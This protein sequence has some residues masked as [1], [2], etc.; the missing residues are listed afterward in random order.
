[1]ECQTADGHVC[2]VQGA[3]GRRHR[4]WHHLAGRLLSWLEMIFDLTLGGPVDFH[5]VLGRVGGKAWGGEWGEKP[6]QAE[7]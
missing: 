3:D 2:R 4:C 5:Q 7:G 1:M 6:F